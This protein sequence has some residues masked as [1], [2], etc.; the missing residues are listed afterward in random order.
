[1]SVKIGIILGTTRNNSLGSKIFKYL[2][3]NFQSN[4]DVEYTWI[5]LKDY[6]L[7]LYDH[8]ETPLENKIHDLNTAEQNWLNIIQQQDGY[9]IL[10]PEY[11]H[12]ITGALKNAL[13]FIGP[14]VAR[15]PIETIA[16]SHFSDGGILAAQSIVPVLQM[17][18]MIVLPT[19]VLLWDADKNFDDHGNLLDVEN[20]E[21]FAKRLNESF[22]EI[23]F[24]TSLLK[25]NPFKG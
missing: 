24:Y 22:T 15:K 11:D 25:N 9:L 14:E 23:N 18:K 3:H 12:A 17:L 13:D 21:H 19:P 7:P 20:S 10:T 1:M 8:I 16:Y 4:A 2:Q 6:P 5:D